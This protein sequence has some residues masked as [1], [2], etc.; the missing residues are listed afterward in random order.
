MSGIVFAFVI[1]REDGRTL[2][3][4]DGLDQR[5]HYPQMPEQLLLFVAQYFLYSIHPVT[6]AIRS[7]FGL[8]S[9]SECTHRDFRR[10][11]PIFIKMG[12]AG[13]HAAAIRTAH[14]KKL[15]AGDADL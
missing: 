12:R 1:S 8:N 5:C 2:C 13:A 3:L 7:S 4:L 6:L 14:E 9:L 10:C 15:S 11:Y